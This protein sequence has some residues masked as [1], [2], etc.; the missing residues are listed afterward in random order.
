MISIARIIGITSSS[1]LENKTSLTALHQLTSTLADKLEENDWRL[2]IGSLL[3]LS[4]IAG[5]I[6]YRYH[7]F[8]SFITQEHLLQLLSTIEKN[9]AESDKTDILIASCIAFG[10][11]TRYHQ[12]P[13]EDQSTLAK[14]IQ[15]SFDSLKKLTKTSKELKVCNEK[16]F[17]LIFRRKS[18]Q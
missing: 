2:K 13:I 5:R 3:G 16:D 15:N 4:Y 12:L 1:G 9:L 7:R 6:A 17:I 14:S 10:E 11:V 8:D 18:L